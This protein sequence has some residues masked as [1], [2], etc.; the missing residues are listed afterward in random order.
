MDFF[1]SREFYEALVNIISDFG[2]LPSYMTDITPIQIGK[3]VMSGS[4]YPFKLRGVICAIYTALEL[5]YSECYKLDSEISNYAIHNNISLVIRTPTRYGL[6]YTIA[7]YNSSLL[8]HEYKNISMLTLRHRDVDVDQY[9]KLVEL[10]EELRTNIRR[11]STIKLK[12]KRDLLKLKMKDHVY[13][14]YEAKLHDIVTSMLYISGDR[15]GK[16]HCKG[17]VKLTYQLLNHYDDVEIKICANGN[18]YIISDAISI[19]YRL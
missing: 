6:P 1:Y 7:I 13:S 8:R 19:L 9:L 2:R 4:V 10:T 5:K 17:N 11:G 12:L 18:S 14:V 3:D 16:K 15:L